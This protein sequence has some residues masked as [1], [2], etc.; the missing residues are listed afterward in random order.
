MVVAQL[1]QSID[2]RIATTS[3]HPEYIN[4]AAGLDHLHRLRALVDAIVVGR[5][6]RNQRRSATHRAPRRRAQSGTGRNRSARTAPGAARLL[7]PDGARRVMILGQHAERRFADGIEVMRVALT[8]GVAAPA[9]ILAGLRAKGFRRILIEGGARTISEFLAAGCLDRLHVMVAPLI[10]GA[11]QPSLALPPI[12]P[13]TV[14]CGRRSRRTCSTAKFCLISICRRSAG[15][16]TTTR[17]RTCSKTR[18]GVV[19]RRQACAA[20]RATWRSGRAA[21]GRRSTPQA[22]SPR[23]PCRRAAPTNRL[24]VKRA[25]PPHRCGWRSPAG[26]RRSHPRAPCRSLRTTTVAQTGPRRDRAHRGVRPGRRPCR[27]SA[28]PARCD[29]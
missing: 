17:V 22:P 26:R 4:G 5:R 3:G 24:A 27:R 10:L 23:L 7:R 13:P 6:H 12:E 16:H 21:S 20:A 29:R 14:R 19:P 9:A 28:A 1:G 11:G 2:G 8:A 25:R 15:H 18:R